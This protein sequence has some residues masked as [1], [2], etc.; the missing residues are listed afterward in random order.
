MKR[1][2]LNTD[3]LT[4]YRI[5]QGPVLALDSFV[6]DGILSLDLVFPRFLLIFS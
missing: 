5:L 2:S 3:C 1:G 4:R 6:R